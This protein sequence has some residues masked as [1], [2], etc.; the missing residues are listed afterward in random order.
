MLEAFIPWAHIDWQLQ[1]ELLIWLGVIFLSMVLCYIRLRQIAVS[2]QD[3]QKP[4]N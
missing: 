4:V 3:N 1:L 2:E